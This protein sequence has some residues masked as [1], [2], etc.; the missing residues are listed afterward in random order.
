MKA[1]Q[2]NVAIPQWVA[3]KALGV[4]SNSVF[5]K[6]PLATVRLVDIPKPKPRD[7]NWAVIKTNYCGFCGSDYNLLMLR[8]SPMASPFTSFPCII[9]HEICGT[10][11]DPGNTGFKKCQRVVIDPMLSCQIRGLQPLCHACA[12]GKP[13]NCE[14]VA[15]GNIA[16]GMFTGICKDINGGFAQYFQAHRLQIH[17]VPSSLS[18]RAA[19]L[20][21]PFSVALQAI[22]DN[23]PQDSDTVCIIGCGVI[24][25]M[26][27]RAIRA[28]NIRS[29]IAIVE[30]SPFHQQKA[31]EYGANTI[32]QGNILNE[33]AQVTGGRVYTPMFGK[34]IIQGG[35]DKV[36]DTVGSSQ[37]F[38][39]AITITR[40]G[41]TVSLVG[42]AHKLSYDPTPLWLK[43][44]TVKGVYG[45]G[46]VVD[47]KKRMHIFDKAIALMTKMPDI[48]HMVTHTFALDQY[49]DMIEVN[50]NKATHKAIKTAV[51]F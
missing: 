28:L 23:K 7:S 32:M 38:N 40:A 1:L 51:E 46:Y 50:K 49:K 9:G 47:N 19:V 15:L 6:G 14:H 24:G 22:F 41:G 26:I 18:D 45:Y 13:A 42:I 44:L 11:E 12:I 48:E 35:F 25:L 21:E 16:P 20:V 10:I 5:Y 29:H 31:I 17:S 37:T 8:D 2:F 43:L 4:F 34:K 36:F 33:V 39:N 30:L 27:I 3:L